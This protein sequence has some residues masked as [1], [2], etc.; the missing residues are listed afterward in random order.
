MSWGIHLCD[1]I[2]K[3]SQLHITLK[4]EVIELLLLFEGRTK[5]SVLVMQCMPRHKN[6][7]AVMETYNQSE[8]HLFQ[9][10]RQDD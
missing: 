10:S 4:N 9:K 7:W 2:F 5:T 8:I 6:L 3:L 1:S